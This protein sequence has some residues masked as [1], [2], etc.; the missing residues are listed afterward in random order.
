M[1]RRSP[2]LRTCSATCDAVKFGLAL[3]HYD[4]SFPDGGP[5]T[6]ERV[7]S[8]AC[9]A[10]RLGFDSV[11]ISDHFFLSL[12][13]YGGSDAPQGTLEP[14]STLAGLATV[15]ERIRLGTLVLCAPFRHPAVLAK[16]ATAVDLLSGGRLTLGLGAG[17]Y[18]EEFAAFGLDF[19]P[20]G[21]R[22]AMLEE[23]FEVLGLLFGEG[24]A[25]YDGRFF[26]LQGAFNRPRPEQWPRPPLM[27]GAKGGPRALEVAAR[28]ADSWNLSWRTTLDG[29]RAKSSA[30]DEACAAVGRD[31]STLSR[32][33]G[34]YT[35]VG[36]DGADLER[37][38][39]A[40]QAWTPG[41]ALDGTSLEDYAVGGLVET[42][43]EV[44]E[45][46]AGFGRLGVSEIVINA[47][48]VPFAVAD[49]SALE[50]FADAVI[51][52]A[53]GL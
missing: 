22:M 5:A 32:S 50:H 20:A 27:L 34:L 19:P 10:E 47:A 26:R 33:V 15:T 23:T 36:A 43:D 30:A 31:P 29:Y 38:Y 37:R 42:V 17:W 2:V 14:L 39:A 28:E 13:R 45:I 40:L 21:M 48:S 6:F 9:E 35:L 41:G 3:P 44:L 52:R 25:D 1:E 7:A 49:R 18:E 4:Y 16:T 8:Y 51:P 24:P 11:W 53:R 46:V 12:A